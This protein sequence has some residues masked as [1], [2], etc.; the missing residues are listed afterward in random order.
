VRIG[1]YRII[2]EIGRGGM[3]LVYRAAR[4]DGLFDQQVA[5]KVI[6]RNVLSPA[7]QDQFATERRILARLHHPHIAHL[8]DGGVSEDGAP[9]IIMELIRGVPITNHAAA[10]NLDLAARLALFRD[11]C[12]A[13][14]YA[15]RELVVH[16]DVKPS[17]VVVAPGFG[18]K[19][20]DFGIARLVGEDGGTAGRAHSP[21]YSSPARLAGER[22]TPTD[23]VFAL[24]VLLHQ[25][26]AGVVGVDED[27]H[28]VAAT[29]ANEDATTRYGAVSDV[30]ADIDRWLGH[31][32][33]NARAPDRRRRLLLLWRRNKVGIAAAGLL[34]LF[35]LAMTGAFLQAS[36]ARDAAEQR[37]AETRELSNFLVSDVVTD[38]ETMPG[39]GPMRQRIA[40]RASVALAKLSQV[41]GAPIELQIETANA[42]ARVGE[43]LAAEDLR[44]AMDPAVGDGVLARAEAA[45]RDLLRQLP[46]RADLRLSLARTLYA[47]AVFAG[48]ARID[49][50]QTFARLD[51]V[52]DLL[53]P[54]LTAE[55]DNFTARLLSARAQMLRADSH[56]AETQYPQ[57]Q[58]ALGR[59]AALLEGLRPAGPRQQADL[60]LAREQVATLLGDAVW[61]GGDH[62]AAVAHYVRGRDALADDALRADIRVLKR[63][64]YTTFTAASSL[65]EVGRVPEAM[66]IYDAGLADLALMRRFDASV[67]ARRMENIV[68]EDYSHALHSLGRIA[69]AYAQNDLAIAGYRENAR[70][71]PG[72]YQV[73]RALPVALRPSGI[74]YL[75]TGNLALA[76]TR[77]REAETIWARLERQNRITDFDRRNDLAAVRAL[78]DRCR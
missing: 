56:S 76:C 1:N 13:L 14:E 33:V 52:A 59:A 21:G 60:A 18:V 4:D 9:Y 57:A 68:R 7:M 71:Q 69:E 78:L 74:L 53:A 77:F 17:N 10:Q 27:L 43:I 28:A 61:Y 2:E 39:T 63:R 55:P 64:A 35:A 11:A 51:E 6:R 26:I 67:S 48:E 23:D 36:L 16:A 50:P 40:E 5:I 49:Q 45:L 65:F 46:D 75:E 37:F 47:R 8:L 32:P 22:S 30:I 42:S 73:L 62:H 25:L 54:I 24:G 29:A 19:L 70:L 41:P 15:H 12:E 66:A 20:L 44:D 31:E 72:N 34:V 3:G 58:A 38:L